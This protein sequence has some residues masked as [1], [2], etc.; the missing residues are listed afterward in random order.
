MQQWVPASAPAPPARGW[1]HQQPLQKVSKPQITDAANA[2]MA[3]NSHLLKDRLL[4]QYVATLS[5]AV[6]TS[7]LTQAEMAYMYFSGDACPLFFDEDID[8]WYAYDKR[9]RAVRSTNL[10]SVR[11]LFQ[12]GF[13]QTVRRVIELAVHDGLFPQTEA[14]KDHPRMDF[15]KKT[16]ASLEK[17]EGVEQIIRESS[18]FFLRRAV[19]DTNPLLF[20]ADKAHSRR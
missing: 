15:L 20:Q 12:S 16:T 4:L 17:R 13:L 18:M 11:A 9:W 5:Q 7:Q 14:G 10:T 6:G 3:S 1:A 19:F 8:A 2:F